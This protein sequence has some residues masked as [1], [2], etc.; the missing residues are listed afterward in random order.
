MLLGLTRPNLGLLN[1][2][3]YAVFAMC[4]T[5]QDLDC[6]V[7][8][9]HLIARRESLPFQPAPE[10]IKQI[11]KG[12]WPVLRED[13]EMQIGRHVSSRFEEVHRHSR[14]GG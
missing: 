13:S 6:V 1:A 3:N 11:R 4:W 2:E 7:D 8:A 5:Y 10:A 9:A 12:R 14:T